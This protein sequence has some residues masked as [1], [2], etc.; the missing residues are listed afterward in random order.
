M[1]FDSV[2]RGNDR[3]IMAA[4]DSGLVDGAHD[5]STFVGVVARNREHGRCHARLGLSMPSPARMFETLEPE[6]PFAA[7]PAM[8]RSSSGNDSFR[9]LNCVNI[10]MISNLR[11][12]CIFGV[13]LSCRS[14]SRKQ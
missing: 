3:N 6:M 4:V 10:T 1:A 2:W 14:I 9:S 5:I 7:F 8:L 13:I 11:K 12:E